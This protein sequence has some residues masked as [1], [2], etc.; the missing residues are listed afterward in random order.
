MLRQN[1]ATI[2]SKGSLIEGIPKICNLRVNEPTTPWVGH[3]AE[4]EGNDNGDRLRFTTI[5]LRLWI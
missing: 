1:V 4:D 5:G 2:E 3:L